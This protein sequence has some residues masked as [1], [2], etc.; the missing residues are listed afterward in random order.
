MF[1]KILKNSLEHI[2]ARVS[3]S[4]TFN[5]KRGSGT[6][7]ILRVLQKFQEHRFY[8]TY[9]EAPSGPMREP[10]FTPSADSIAEPIFTPSADSIADKQPRFYSHFL[11]KNRFLF[12]AFLL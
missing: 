10:I 12:F 9:P 6:G 11:K 3:F 1:L 7:G 4:C 8:R 5:K 2:C